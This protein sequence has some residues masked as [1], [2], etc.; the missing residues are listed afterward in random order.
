MKEGRNSV[1]WKW[2]RRECAKDLAQRPFFNGRVTT[3]NS[4]LPTARDGLCFLIFLCE[5]QHDVQ[6]SFQ[7]ASA[8]CFALA[9]LAN[10]PP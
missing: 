1:R 2:R 3:S 7:A 5:D 4:S 8:P 10:H 9:K 6:M